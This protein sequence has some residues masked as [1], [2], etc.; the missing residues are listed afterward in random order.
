VSWNGWSGRYRG[1]P[2]PSISG[3]AELERVC[4]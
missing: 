3:P 1:I 4:C 2:A